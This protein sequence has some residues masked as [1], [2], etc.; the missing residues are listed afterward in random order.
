MACFK[1]TATS[2]SNFMITF[3]IIIIVINRILMNSMELLCIVLF[4]IFLQRVNK[5]VT[6][7]M[8]LHW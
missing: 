1:D 5:P 2:R 8:E 6:Q 4:F 7:I 3:F